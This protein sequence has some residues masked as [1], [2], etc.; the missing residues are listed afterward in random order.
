[1]SKKHSELLQVFNNTE[2]DAER[3]W[4]IAL[5]I[6]KGI[7]SPM[8]A[9]A[10]LLAYRMMGKIIE[11]KGDTDWLRNGAPHCH[12]RRD[13]VDTDRGVMKVSDVTTVEDDV[14]LP[15]QSY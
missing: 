13:Y 9:R 11:T 2:A 6:W 7:T 5:E 12:V 15:S 10:I 8:V 1:M 3:I 14:S 4:K